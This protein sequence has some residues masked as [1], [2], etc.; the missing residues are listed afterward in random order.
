MHCFCFSHTFWQEGSWLRAATVSLCVSAADG[1]YLGTQTWQLSPWGGFTCRRDSA[2]N[3]SMTCSVNM[4]RAWALKHHS[5]CGCANLHVEGAKVW[6]LFLLS[7]VRGI[8]P[9][10]YVLECCHSMSGESM[11]FK[12]DVHHVDN[13]R[14]TCARNGT[15][16][17]FFVNAR[18]L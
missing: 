10:D 16:F 6:G 1:F 13:L 17:V 12:E 14:S 7:I 9:S 5:F 18:V 3:R 8:L 2:P 4:R 15:G 11:H